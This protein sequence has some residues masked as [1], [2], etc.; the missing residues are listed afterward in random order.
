MPVG[1]RCPKSNL[2]AIIR[3]EILAVYFFK[4]ALH[5]TIP[6]FVYRLHNSYLAGLSI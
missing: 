1:V 3:H 6:F 2:I 5:S 4:N